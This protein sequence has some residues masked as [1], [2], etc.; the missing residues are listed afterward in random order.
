MGF[1]E[2]II[3][4]GEIRHNPVVVDAYVKQRLTVN[5]ATL[6]RTGEMAARVEAITEAL[7]RFTKLLYELDTDGTLA[8][9]DFRTGRIL[10]PAPF[11]SVGWK[12][13][14]LRDWEGRV[15]RRFLM[16]RCRQRAG[17]PALF[18][19]NDGQRTWHI[20]NVDYATWIDAAGFLQ[21]EPLTVRALK[22]LSDD[23]RKK[24]ASLHGTSHDLGVVRGVIT[25]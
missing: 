17:R 2:Q 18:D 23:Y 4:I 5:T 24:R 10:I 21:T 6:T 11:G 15:V 7:V 20:N 12:R 16:D 1:D 19:F 14:G 25:A 9:V 8:N 3:R 22:K 13:W